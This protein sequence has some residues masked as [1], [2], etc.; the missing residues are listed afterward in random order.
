MKTFI[1]GQLELVHPRDDYR[2]LLQLAAGMVGLDSSQFSATIRK[3]GAL[4]RARWTAKEIYSLK[5]QLL[6]YG[7]E[8]VIMLTARELQGIKR[9]NKF[10]VQVYLQSWFTSRLLV[11]KPYNDILLIQRLDG[12]DDAALKTTGLKMMLRHSW[13]LSQE[14]ATVSLFSAWL[15]QS[16]ENTACVSNER[17]TWSAFGEVFL[18]H[19]RDY[20]CL[21]VSSKLL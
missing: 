7:N 3:P 12:Y 9:F 17:R 15:S 4:H 13:Y 19:C 6:L 14:L 8:F 16:R 18:V 20:L 1:A 11:H 2:E 10:V 21:A 5:M